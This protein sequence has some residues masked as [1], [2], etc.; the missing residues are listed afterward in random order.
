[1]NFLIIILLVTSLLLTRVSRLKTAVTIILIQSF[2]VALA[3]GIDGLEAGAVHMYVA[4]ILT[5]VIKVGLI[6]YALLNIVEKLQYER[7]DHPILN[8]N[9]SSVTAC[10]A[11][12]LAYGLIDQAL[13]GANSRDALATALAMTLI[14]LLI[15]MTRRQAI[16]QIV[17]LI[18]MENGIYLV[19][20]SA[21]KGLPLIIEMGIFFDVLVAV[22]VLVILTH[23]LKL[24]GMS[25]DISRLKKLK[26]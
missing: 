8:V 1:M 3:C 10:I 5:A 20:L 7:E 13:P 4:A 16:M 23:R 21:T 24:S 18:T 15:I 25:T 26:G 9:S 6:P 11:I 14:G 17:G 22:V 19:G 12:V 2:M